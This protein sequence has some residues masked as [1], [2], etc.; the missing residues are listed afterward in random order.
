MIYTKTTIMNCNGK[1]VIGGREIDAKGR[2][3]EINDNCVFIDG[4][5]A[6]Q[7][8]GEE[9][10]VLKI[11]IMGNVETIETEDADVTV[12]GRVGSISSKNGNVQAQ[13]VEGDIVSK[14]GNVCVNTCHGS[15][16]TKNGNIIRNF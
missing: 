8:K 16:D 10:P 3:I 14:N 6:E 1:M 15:C 7:F 11:E 13:T 9:R 5:P 12:N 2:K 4:V